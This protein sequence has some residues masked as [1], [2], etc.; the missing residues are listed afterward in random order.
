MASSARGFTLIELMVVVAVIAIL[1]AIAFPSFREQVRKSRRSEA[2]AEV[3]RLQLAMERWRAERPSYANSSPAAATY[4][5]AVSNAY[6]TIAI[7]GQAPTA[8]T[9]TATPAGSQVGDRCGVLTLTATSKPTWAT[10]SCN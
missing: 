2:V 6:Y 7:S 5:T 4:P 10:A 9:V 8:Y 1:A 3:G